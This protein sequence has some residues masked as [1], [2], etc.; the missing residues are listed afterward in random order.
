[1]SGSRCGTKG[2][3]DIK[4][5]FINILAKMIS[6][7]HYMTFFCAICNYYLL[8]YVQTW[9]ELA[10]A[11]VYSCWP[12]PLFIPLAILLQVVV[13]IWQKNYYDNSFGR[14]PNLRRGLIVMRD[15]I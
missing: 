13:Y 1:M 2:T 14:Y 10:H 5:A 15:K 3:K 8:Y 9:K 6:Y 12:P 11:G 7:P 4:M